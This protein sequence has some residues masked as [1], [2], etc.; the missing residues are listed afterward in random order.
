MD[1]WMD[2]WMD[3]WIDVWT[4]AVIDW[5]VDHRGGWVGGGMHGR[6]SG[7]KDGVMT[8]FG[9]STIKI[10]EMGPSIRRMPGKNVSIRLVC[11]HVWHFLDCWSM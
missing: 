9:L 1:G 11:G 3:K 4:P 8:N 5:V 7:W 10:W 6:M 2:G